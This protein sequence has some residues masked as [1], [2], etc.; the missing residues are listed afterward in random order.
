MDIGGTWYATF[1]D[2]NVAD[3]V[4]GSDFTSLDTKVTVSR[5]DKS[6]V[7]LKVLWLPLWIKRNTVISFLEQ[8]GKVVS[9]AHEKETSEGVKF[10]NGNIKVTLEIS[11]QD[12]KSLPYRT[13]VAGKDC[14]LTVVG[15]APLC[16][17]C[18]TVGHI[19]RNCPLGKKETVPLEEVSIPETQISDISDETP[20]VIDD[21]VDNSPVTSDTVDTTSVTPDT[22]DTSPVLSD[23]V[24]T[25]KASSSSK[26]WSDRSH[27]PEDLSVDKT[28]TVVS[29]KKRKV[30]SVKKEQCQLRF[31]RRDSGKVEPAVGRIDEHNML[32][33]FIYNAGDLFYII[34]SE[35]DRKKHRQLI[36]D[37]LKESKK[38]KN[39][40]VVVSP[41][42]F[43][44]KD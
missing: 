43:L 39:Y 15:R 1:T 3:K 44:Y 27:E 7:L 5:A 12:I 13:K 37:S 2:A 4:I 36:Q 38:F 32:V 31:I 14:L 26:F 23:T 41:S 25:D 16:L 33:S 34:G 22:V 19:R 30:A 17:K 8:F 6:T 18:N 10:C 20:L 9:C 21:T 42:Y 35:P 24:D 40:E 29:G 11:E 28:F